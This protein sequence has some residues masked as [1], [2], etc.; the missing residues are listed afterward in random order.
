MNMITDKDPTELLTCEEATEILR[1][2][3]NTLSRLLKDGSLHAFKVGRIWKI[4]VGGIETYIRTQS[5]L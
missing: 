4:P 5:K 2:G 3:Y 1:C